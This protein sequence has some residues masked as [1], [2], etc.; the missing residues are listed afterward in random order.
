[1]KKKQNSTVH[2]GSKRNYLGIRN[3][4]P[5]SPAHRAGIRKNDRILSVNG[6]R[7]TDDLDF[8][9]F[10]S[11][12]YVEIEGVSNDNKRYVTVIER[13][14]GSTLGIEFY[15]KPVGRCGNKCIFCFI[16]QMPRGLR[17]GL[18][19]KDEDIRHSFLNGN[20]VTLATSGLDDLQWVAQLGLSPLYISVHTTDTDVRN[21]MLGNRKAPAIM[22]QLAFL[23]EN[24]VRFH[25]QV[26]VCP[27]YNDD[28]MLKKTIHDLFSLGESLLS[29]AI[30]PVGITRFREKPLKPVDT[31]TA[32]NIVDMVNVLSDYYTRCDGFRRLFL[33]DEFFVKSGYALPPLPYYEDFPQIENGVGLICQLLE[34]WKNIKR[35]PKVKAVSTRNATGKIATKPHVAG[36]YSLGQALNYGVNS[37][38]ENTDAG[39]TVVVTSVSGSEHIKKVVD[40]IQRIYSI[41]TVSAV[42]IVNTFLGESV[43]VAG[44][45]TAK[46]VIATVR[47]LKKMQKIKQIVLPEVMFNYAGYTLDG[48]SAGRIGRKVQCQVKK[49]GSVSDM[50]SIIVSDT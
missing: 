21:A 39:M 12:E 13:E 32:R 34:E 1:M 7:V 9:F 15:E 6:E 46:D 27:G 16:D 42:P 49:A 43:T 36:R 30:V 2:I 3:V 22:D 29:I 20:Y 33:A 23:E 48:Y 25:T 47:R 26:V 35:D 28:E 24:G 17:K 19:V 4:L 5:Q 31:D 14:F 11:S 50:L 38:A 41:N 44:L 40:E 37:E 45:L 8:Y 10:S 18:Y